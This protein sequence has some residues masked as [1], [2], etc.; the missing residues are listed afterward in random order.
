[1]SLNALVRL[2]HIVGGDSEAFLSAIAW[3]KNPTRWS[4]SGSMAALLETKNPEQI[5]LIDYRQAV[6]GQNTALISCAG[7]V[8]A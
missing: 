2:G 1:M 6:N 5:E 3:T 8:M 7:L 4:G